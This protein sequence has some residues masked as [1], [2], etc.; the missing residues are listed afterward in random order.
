MRS[1]LARAAQGFETFAA[2]T[3]A[4]RFQTTS[5]RRLPFFAV[6]RAKISTSKTSI[7]R[8][9]KTLKM[10]IRPLRESVFT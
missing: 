8:A 2:T 9:G 10:Y 7:Q 1:S 5:D 4:C 6:E 3:V